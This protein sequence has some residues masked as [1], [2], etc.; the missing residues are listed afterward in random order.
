MP[1]P[2]AAAVL[3]LVNKSFMSQVRCQSY[4]RYTRQLPDFRGRNNAEVA[5]LRL[6]AG[7][8]RRNQTVIFGYPAGVSSMRGLRQRAFQFTFCL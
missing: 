2:A 7:V 3:L 6:A 1:P 5:A 8:I 4:R